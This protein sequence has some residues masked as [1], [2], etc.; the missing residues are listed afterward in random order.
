MS[1]KK[2]NIFRRL[3]YGVLKENP[4]V[5]L[6]LGLC[7]TL[8]VTTSAKNGLAMGIFTSVVLIL[9]NL[10]ISLLRKLIPQT[11]RILGFVVII[12][13]FTTLSQ[14]FLQA[15]FPDINEALGIFIPLTAV[16][17]VIYDRAE[18][19]AVSHNAALSIFDG[20]GMGIG[21]TLIIT[22]LGAIREILAMG[23][24][25]GYRLIPAGYSISIAAL[26]PGGFIILAC[27]IAIAN[28]INGGRRL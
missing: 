17:T 2:D 9:S 23:T 4:T 8:A 27:I 15:Y 13:T 25:F 22:I 14:L 10:F 28:K 21:Y 16:N 20:I 11:E 5:V 18:K 26:A 1:E 19:Y 12:G 24:V 7:P 3:Y 6:C